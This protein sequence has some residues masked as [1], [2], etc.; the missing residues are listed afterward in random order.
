M[1]KF[2]VKAQLAKLQLGP[3]GRSLLWVALIFALGLWPFAA[4]GSNVL[5]EPN[6][7]ECYLGI[8]PRDAS[9]ET[10]G[11]PS[12]KRPCEPTIETGE[13]AWRLVTT[14]DRQV[15]SEFVRA[16]PPFLAL[17]CAVVLVVDARLNRKDVYTA[18]EVERPFDMAVAQAAVTSIALAAIGGFAN[19]FYRLDEATYWLYKTVL[20]VQI[21]WMRD[22]DAVERKMYIGFGVLGLAVLFGLI[23]FAYSVYYKGRFCDIYRR[24]PSGRLNGAFERVGRYIFHRNYVDASGKRM[25]RVFF[26]EGFRVMP[27]FR[28]EYVDIEAKDGNFKEPVRLGLSRLAIECGRLERTTS[29][30]VWRRVPNSEVKSARAFGNNFRDDLTYFDHA[31][32]IAIVQKGSLMN[33]DAARRKYA[34]DSVVTIGDHRDFKLPPSVDEATVSVPVQGPVNGGRRA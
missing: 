11:A 24:D 17:L 23:W 33:P 19:L 10:W 3:R 4:L 5:A 32:K 14:P 31:R 16:V 9:R 27:L 6:A 18:A 20:T 21:W 1:P 15:A 12:A 29:A 13:H 22:V 8:D 34:T 25:T 2:D 28:F 7:A 26:K 30:D